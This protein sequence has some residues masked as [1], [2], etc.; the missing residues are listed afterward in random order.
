MLLSIAGR[1]QPSLHQAGHRATGPGR[2]Q[3]QAVLPSALD[4]VGHTQEDDIATGDAAQTEPAEGNYAEDLQLLNNQQ[5]E[6]SLNRV[7]LV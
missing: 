4:Q 1:P 5:C 7:V 2:V 3:D 6:I